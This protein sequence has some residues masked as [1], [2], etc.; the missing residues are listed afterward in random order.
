MDRSNTNFV[1]KRRLFLLARNSTDL[2]VK[3]PFPFTSDIPE[4]DE[5]TVEGLKT[6]FMASKGGPE[7]FEQCTYCSTL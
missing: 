2:C 6:V 5:G 3:P 7:G 1:S 4:S